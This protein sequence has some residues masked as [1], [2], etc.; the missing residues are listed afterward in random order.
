MAWCGC[1]ASSIQL[2]MGSVLY[3]YGLWQKE[4][5][6]RRAEM[7]VLRERLEGLLKADHEQALSHEV[8]DN[9]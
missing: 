2:I 8:C 4:S 1:L 7:S 6:I 9:C 3:R 5:A